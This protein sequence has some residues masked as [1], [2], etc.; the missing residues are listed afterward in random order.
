MIKFVKYLFAA[1]LFFVFSCKGVK[2]IDSKTDDLQNNVEQN[3]LELED[4]LLW[5]ISGNGLESTSYL[6]GTIHLIPKEDFFWP[7]GTLSALENS[8]QAYFEVDLDDMFDISAQMGLLTKAFMNDGQT[9]SDFYSKE[10][11]EMVKGHFEGL[12]IPMFFLEKLKPMFLT[13]FASGDVEF[14][15]GFGGDSDVKSYEMEL[16]EICQDS[17]KDVDGLETIEYQISVF[18]SIP[19]QD[20]ADMLLETIKSSDAEND[21]FQEM[22]NMYKE[23][24]IDDM[25]ST[26]SQEEAGIQGYEDV[27]LNNRNKNWIPVMES[28]MKESKT[29]FAVGAG[30]LAG[31]EGVIHL[32]RKQG[33]K[34]K[35]LSQQQG[36]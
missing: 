9:L 32:L 4:A 28:K 30:H 22:V 21:M 17:N 29:F 3:S 11:Y 5:E 10:D 13:V 24:R 27:L 18:D 25:V 15:S 34:L 31:E 33:Y 16:Y 36:I 12:G 14:G 6:Y 35:P 23:Q 20:Q 1:L 26:M 19:Y 7:K 2:D 8:T